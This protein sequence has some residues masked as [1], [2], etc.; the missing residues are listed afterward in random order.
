M[1][2]FSF[3]EDRFEINLPRAIIL[4]IL[5]HLIVLFLLLPLVHKPKIKLPQI[6]EV[7]LAEAQKENSKPKPEAPKKAEPA[8]QPVKIPEPIKQKPLEEKKV[9]SKPEL[10]PVEKKLES[11]PIPNEKKEV[12]TKDKTLPTP[13]DIIK[14][15]DLSQEV[16]TGT[17]SPEKINSV[18]SD[19]SNLL[20]NAIAK[21]KQY[22]K[23]AQM[24]GWQ[25]IVIVELELSP[26][27]SILSMLIKKSSGYEILDSEAMQMIQRASPLPQPPETLRTKNFTVLVPISFVLN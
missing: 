26:S 22:P 24:R 2:K 23:L 25:G 21:Y 7:K 27:G 17:T 5:F 13:R 12:V 20:A 1:K 4:S 6:L 9:E 3:D 18:K 11:L 19:Y 10:K 15:A 14:P 8:P 16:I